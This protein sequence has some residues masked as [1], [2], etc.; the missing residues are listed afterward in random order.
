MILLMLQAMKNLI[1]H[2]WAEENNA[3][4][5]LL[6]NNVVFQMYGYVKKEV[7]VQ[8]GIIFA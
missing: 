8:G 3:A 4:Q 7:S 2:F 1:G 5:R 6:L